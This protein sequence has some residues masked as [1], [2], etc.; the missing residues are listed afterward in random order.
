MIRLFVLCTLFPIAIGIMLCTAL[1]AQQFKAGVVAGMVTSQVDGDT[2]SGYSKAGLFAGGFV[3]KRFSSESKWTALFEIT[4]I[5]KGS[6]KVPH[7]DKGDFADYK[8]KLD[9]AEVPLLVKYDFA[10]SDSSGEG[11]MNFAVLG[12]IAVGALVNFEESDAFGVV[13]GGTP[14][15]KTDISYLLGLSYF[16]SK[17]IG[18][19]VR[20]I[21]SIV[22]VR[23]GGSSTYYQNWTYKFFKPGYYNNL[24][25]FS[26]RYRF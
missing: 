16:V 1:R 7:P 4:Y 2:Y 18:F 5:Q 13:I 17:H 9:Y 21:Y 8:L 20:T 22:P 26:L 19:E 25:V 15:Q 24:L 12:G 11:K 6:R 23:K 10:V 14:F 3:S